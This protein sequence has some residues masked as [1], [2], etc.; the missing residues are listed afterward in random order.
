[1]IESEATLIGFASLAQVAI[2]RS[3]LLLLNWVV[4]SQAPPLLWFPSSLCYTPFKIASSKSS[5]AL[6]SLIA[7][8]RNN[9]VTKRKLYQPE[10]K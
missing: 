7:F 5:D 10:S 9:L 4:N 8:K 1:M 6:W 2:K 3:T